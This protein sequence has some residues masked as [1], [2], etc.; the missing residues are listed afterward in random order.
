MHKF[1]MTS[2]SGVFGNIRGSADPIHE[3]EQKKKNQVKSFSRFCDYFQEVDL[4][5]MIV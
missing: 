5:R 4:L 2:L 1:K 3:K